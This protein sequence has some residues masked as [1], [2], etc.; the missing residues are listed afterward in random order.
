MTITPLTSAVT[1][2]GAATTAYTATMPTGL[3]QDDALLAVVTSQG[4]TGTTHSAPAG[5]TQLPGCNVTSGGATLRVSAWRRAAT[6]SEVATAAFTT[7]NAQVGGVVIM[8]YR[9]V[10]LTALAATTPSV[11]VTDPASTTIGTTAYTTTAAD[12]YVVL[13]YGINSSSPTITQPTAYTDRGQSTGQKTGISDK[14][15]TASG[16]VENPSA[17]SSLSRHNIAFLVELIP[18]ATSSSPPYSG[19]GGGPTFKGVFG[20]EPPDNVSDADLGRQTMIL[21][22]NHKSG[23][24]FVAAARGVNPD[25][26]TA[27]YITTSEVMADQSLPQR[28]IML[29]AADF[30]AI[31]ESHFLH[32]KPNGGF[33]DRIRNGTFNTHYLDPASSAFRTIWKTNWPTIRNNRSWC[34]GLYLDNLMYDPTDLIRHSSTDRIFGIGNVEYT[35]SNYG[36]ALAAM[37]LDLVTTFRATWPND[38]YGGNLINM[39]GNADLSGRWGFLDFLAPEA[40]TGYGNRYPTDGY[41]RNFLLECQQFVALSS[42]KI[43]ISNGQTNTVPPSLSLTTEVNK[44]NFFLAFHAMMMP[45]QAT[46]TYGSKVWVRSAVRWYDHSF[47]AIWIYPTAQMNRDLGQPTGPAIE[48]PSYVFTRT[49]EKGIVTCDIRAKEGRFELTGGTTPPPP[50]T[51]VRV[52]VGGT[53]SSWRRMTADY[54]RAFRFRLPPERPTLAPVSLEV[55]EIEIADGAGNA[56]PG[57]TQKLRWGIFSHNPTTNKANTIL[58]GESDEETFAGGTLQ[59]NLTRRWDFPMPPGTLTRGTDQNPTYYWLVALASEVF[60]AT[61]DGFIRLPQSASD[62][63]NNAVWYDNDD[64]TNGIA[65]AFDADNDA[66]ESGANLIV[67]LIEQAVIVVAPAAPTSPTATALGNGAIRLQW[68]DASTNEEGFRIERSLSAAFTLFDVLGTVAAGVHTYTDDTAPPGVLVY[69]RI[70]AYNAGG[71]GTSVVVS[72]TARLAGSPS[73]PTLG[74]SE[75][76]IWV[77]TPDGVKAAEIDGTAY[78]DLAYNKRRREPGVAQWTLTASHPALRYLVDKAQVLI[79]RRNVAAGIPWYV[80]FRGLIRVVEQITDA[81]GVQRVTVM[82]LGDLHRLQSRIVAYP[83]GLVDITDFAGRSAEY[84]AKRIVALNCTDAATVT[85]GRTRT[86]TPLPLTIE[87]NYDRGVAVSWRA[88]WGTVLSELQEL[89]KVSN[90]DF[91]LVGVGANSW[92]FRFYA[93]QRGQDLRETVVFSV[94]QGTMTAPRLIHD[95]RET[96]TVAIVGGRGEG[97]LREVRVRTNGAHYRV[98]NEIEV[99]VDA[100]QA[101]GV[102]TL[103]TKG[104]AALDAAR[105]KTQLTFKVRQTASTMYGKHYSVGGVLGD[106]VTATYSGVTVELEIQGVTVAIDDLGQEQ[107]DVELR[108]VL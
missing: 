102:A 87:P 24:G 55:S 44:I 17:T 22:P 58:G 90:G 79:W 38:A 30:A 77:M 78:R 54:E 5:W 43:I 25:I 75:C 34:D 41:L 16:T 4:G 49:F 42:K 51:E 47:D 67:T 32:D 97:T 94:E 56:V 23:T 12:A 73:Q 107:I 91:D 8:A 104:D 37:V 101:E 99:F 31:P 33:A 65:A 95:E 64:Y 66:T 53:R 20:H 70:V 57:G 71:V 61:S 82:A 11:K 98:D 69:Y 93:G 108:E 14:L 1:S 83:P 68:V 96:R 88:A 80:D 40:T 35:A 76:V 6:N 86:A 81:D 84:I 36:P 100:R 2:F 85:N 48:Q 29:S 74:L 19:L 9:G 60:D 89:A 105:P 62:S 103:D 39:P 27:I 18:T 92:E 10:D 50:T 28:T 52:T 46:T 7:S 72:A 59:T 45:Q 21:F 3:Q 13:L 63:T 106:R 15:I 26:R